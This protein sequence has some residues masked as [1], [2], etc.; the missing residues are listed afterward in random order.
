MKKPANIKIILYY[1]CLFELVLFTVLVY[2]RYR[3]PVSLD[4]GPE[5]MTISEMFEE[6]NYVEGFWGLDHWLMPAKF[7]ARAG[8]YTVTVSYTLV[9]SGVS[10]TSD[11]YILTSPYIFPMAGGDE[12]QMSYNIIVTDSRKP[13]SIVCR[14]A[15]GSGDFDNLTVHGINVRTAS[16]DLLNFALKLLFLFLVID[17]IFVLYIKR[18]FLKSLTEQQRFVIAALLLATFF[19]SIPNFA[20]YSL[21]QTDLDF[22]MSRIEGIKTGLLAGSFPVRIQPILLNNHGYASS[23]LYGELFLYLPALLRLAGFTMGFCYS[24]YVVLMNFVTLLIAYFCF[25]KV[26][27]NTYI[28]LAAAFVYASSIYRLTN[29]YVRAAVGEYTAMTFFPLILYGLWAVYTYHHEDAG[30]K[31]QGY[32]RLWIPLAIG[33]TG[34][35]QS[36]TISTMLVGIIT[37]IVCLIMWKQ[38]FKKETFFVLLKTVV[39]TILVNLWFL[40]PFLDYMRYEWQGNTYDDRHVRW[41][42]GAAIPLPQLFMANYVEPR[43]NGVTYNMGLMPLLIFMLCLLFRGAATK[44]EKKREAF[45]LVSIAVL[46]FATTPLFPWDR[47]EMLFPPFAFFAKTLQFPWRLNAFTAFFAAWLLCFL[48]G[49][50]TLT[51]QRIVVIAIV[52]FGFLEAWDLN[53]K[54]LLAREHIFVYEPIGKFLTVAMGEF[55]PAGADTADYVNALTT[56]EMLEVT[57]SWRQYNKITVSLINYSNQ[58]DFIEVP[59]INYPGYR[60]VDLE[61]GAR[62]NVS[63]GLSSRV[64]VEVPGSYSGSFV[65][66]FVSPWYWR[67]AEAV[68]VLTI[69]VLAAWNFRGKFVRRKGVD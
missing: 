65:V 40:L 63:D 36:H 53:S 45:C 26:A 54:I 52:V 31:P 48:A 22:H 62:L 15:D 35:I 39:V 29:I 25:K 27:G 57:G 18:D 13:F 5:D 47:L 3:S 43:G 14:L 69:V 2:A 24:V 50:L 9:G 67:L 33:Y 37:V 66:R 11:H 4:F 7:T 32:K 34:V 21:D 51:K 55:L 41:L 58:S 10:H 28:G 23:V 56:G 42:M 16:E 46:V 44:Q 12:Q 49:K 20:E 61:T 68:S 64:K 60:A 6:R 17:A 8:V 19:L 30:D 1:L 59:L 38:T